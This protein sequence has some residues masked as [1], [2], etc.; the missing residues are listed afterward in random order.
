MKLKILFFCLLYIYACTD[1]NALSTRWAADVTPENVWQEYPR[2]IMERERWQNLNG[3]WDY[4]ILPKSSVRP[5]TFDGKILVPFPVESELSGVNRFVGDENELWYR[6]TFRVPSSWRGD[7][8]L[9][10]FG[11]VDWRCDVWVN[12]VNVGS[13]EGGYSPF[14][15]NVTEALRPGDNEITVRVYDPSDSGP[16]PRGKQVR[17]PLGIWYTPVTGI[18]QTVWLEPV[19]KNHIENIKITP[20]IDANRLLV[21]ANSSKGAGTVRIKVLEDGKTVAEG[22]ALAGNPVEIA[23]PK[24]YKLWSPDSPNLYD[25]EITL[26]EKGK[27]VDKVD[28]YAAMRK[29]STKRDGKGVVRM[30]LN[31]K[32][33]FQFGPLDQGWWPDGLYTAPSYEA[34]IYDIDMTKKFGY[35]MI[36]KHVKTEPALWYTY[37]DRAGI[38]VWQDMPSGDNNVNAWQPH[39]YFKGVEKDRNPESDAIYRREW[40]EI[41]DNLHNYPCIVTWVPF[42]EGW[43]QYNT[44]ET[45]NWTKAY[46]PSRLVNPASG[47]NFFDCGDIVDVHNYPWPRIYLLSEGK[48]NVIGEYGGIGYAIPEHTWAP[49][50]NW[51][52]VKYNSIPEVTAEYINFVKMLRTLSEIA[53]TAAVYTQ[54]TDVEIEV[55]GLMT[56]DREII[57]VDVD[58]VAEANRRLI[59]DF[60]K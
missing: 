27:A 35:N 54:T 3:N 24:G 33:I 30:Q 56:Y 48:A 7:D 14:T 53:Y 51:G 20:D 29:I 45:A 13:H 50:R 38:L 47:G 9:L 23:M 17:K 26:V 28:S 44:V 59:K 15:F 40:K 34:M 10:H 37:C 32:D 36:R 16:Q 31:N 58:S 6:R 46:D 41:M 8:V 5:E 52:Y 25:L 12:G 57:K 43:G 4:A 22:M 39:D 18:W 11:A 19:P 42:N 49:D 1:G 2:P 21:A 60:S 55:N